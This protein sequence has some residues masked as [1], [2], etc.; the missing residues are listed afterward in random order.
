MIESMLRKICREEKT[1]E[2]IKLRIYRRTFLGIVMTNPDACEQHFHAEI[3]CSTVLISS[4][5]M[6]MAT[7]DQ[8]E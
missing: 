1:F 5:T 6:D 8:N 7:C 2:D 4:L 3:T